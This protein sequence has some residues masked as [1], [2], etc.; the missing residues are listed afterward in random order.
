MSVGASSQCDAPAQN[1]S[2]PSR[3]RCAVRQDEP[4]TPHKTAF[5]QC[6]KACGSLG[7]QSTCP[8]KLT[9]VAGVRERHAQACRV[10]NVSRPPKLLINPNLLCRPSWTNPAQ[11][12]SP[13]LRQ[14]TQQQFPLSWSRWSG[15]RC[16][17]Q[18]LIQHIYGKKLSCSVT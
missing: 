8:M 3:N 12:E 9:R 4:P 2:T 18:I 10:H 15:T 1:Q 5:A 11:A 13:P 17:T 16:A 14:E 7:E 6:L